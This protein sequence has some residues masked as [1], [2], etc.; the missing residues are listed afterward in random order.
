MA[1]DDYQK[2]LQPYREEID[3]IDRQLVSLLNRRA[4]CAGD[5][6]QIKRQFAQPIYNQEREH[7]VLNQIKNTNQGPLD[8][9]HLLAVFQEI[10]T[11][12]KLHESAVQEQ[13]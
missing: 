8:H 13:S 1:Q 12:M 5:I 11:Q 3:Q 6:A 7:T 4:R 2:A 9:H 10:M